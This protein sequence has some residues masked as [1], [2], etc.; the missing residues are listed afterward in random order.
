MKNEITVSDMAGM[1][2]EIA[3]RMEEQASL[4]CEM[5]AQLGD[6]DLGLTMKKGFGAI[7]DI[8]HGIREQ[9]I[10]RFLIEIGLN[11]A[12]A[13]PSTMGTLMGSGIISGGKM[14]VGLEKIDS[15]GFVDFLDGF[16]NGI[17]KRGK[18]QRGDCTVLDAMI[19]ALDEAKRITSKSSTLVETVAAAVE[20]AR[21]GVESTKSMTPKFGKAAVHAK[22][23]VGVVDQ[24][25]CAGLFFLEGIKS[26]VES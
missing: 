4:L 19:T 24:G 15:T 14:L 8:T 5:D 9:D 10:G 11:L 6:G 12:S 26:Y 25:A 2:E 16:C 20:G 23:A 7:P 21:L 3:R 22:A 18:C 1:F 17:M 13:V